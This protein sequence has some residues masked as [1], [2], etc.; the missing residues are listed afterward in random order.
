[1]W[2]YVC[3]VFIVI[4]ILLLSLLYVEVKKNTKK[5]S[6]KYSRLNK[7]SNF[8][9]CLGI[10]TLAFVVF[11]TMANYADRKKDTFERSADGFTI[12]NFNIEMN[13]NSNNQV[14]VKEYITVNFYERRH[15]GIY[16]FIPEWLEYTGKDGITKS[17][18]ATIRDLK[19][20][21]EQYTVDTV[22]GKKRIKIGNS[23]RTLRTGEYTYVIEYMCDFGGDIYSGYDEFIFHAFGDY[24]GTTIN[25]ASVKIVFPKEITN[26]GSIRFFTDKKRENDITS[27]VNYTISENTIFASIPSLTSALTI[28]V[29][30]PEGYFKVSNS[31]IYGSK[32]LIS[33]ISCIVLSVITFLVW[34]INGRNQNKVPET[35]EFYPPENM[36]ASEIGYLYKKDSG[37]K[38]GIALIIELASKGFIKIE[39]S[40]DKKTITI[41]K[42]RVT[43]VNKYIKREIRISKLK[44]YK[45]HI[46]TR[47]ALMEKYFPDD[48]TQN[49][50]TSDFDAFY[51]ESKY[52]VD[53]SH[54]K[55]E[56]DTIDKYSQEELDI[57]KEK[58]KSEEFK[59]KPELTENEKLVYDALFKSGDVTVLSQNEN[60][61][62][63]FSKIIDKLSKKYDDIFNDLKTYSFKAVVSFGFFICTILWA[64]AFII[65][66]DMDT[67][68]SILYY[69]AFASNI[70]TLIFAKLINKKGLYGEQID[71]KIEGFKDYL[72][73]AEK[74]QIEL[75]VK[76][77]P[78]YYY[79]ILP[80]AYVLDVS[81]KWIERFENVTIPTLERLGNFDYYSTDSLNSLGNSVRYPSSS[82]DS[83]SYG[84]C[85]GG[86]GGGCSS[87]GGGG[88]W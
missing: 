45:S 52:L 17:K 2:I 68:F 16:R 57:I 35:V 70:I 82:R 3:L 6:S 56:S 23:A 54:I 77:N 65:F 79:D 4:L 22:N 53:H 80:Y 1:M 67:K 7:I 14:Y 81:K 26:K 75:M 87:C 33:C 41:S 40:E 74:N 36:D 29:E 84:G 71:A 69:I 31:S 30:L 37:R 88:G 34:L 44:D 15:H 66:K 38:L 72:E 48:S 11:F 5:S 64:L 28:D 61:Y 83:S 43:D 49:V 78:K 13:V 8:F 9:S 42:D 50:I 63:V 39:E 47:K 58:L 60:F 21:G 20:I 18:K 76:E 10:I 12:E 46:I 86:C 51:K 55:I 62:K 19:A 25:N 32:S 59:D 24:W 73:K 85:G 27:K